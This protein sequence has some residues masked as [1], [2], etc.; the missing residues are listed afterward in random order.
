MKKSFLDLEKAFHD[1]VLAELKTGMRMKEKGSVD[2]EKLVKVIRDLEGENRMISVRFKTVYY[3][4]LEA[5]KT[6]ED[7]VNA[8]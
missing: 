1:N 4:E 6:Q 5:S 3:Q 8:S 2:Y 7:H